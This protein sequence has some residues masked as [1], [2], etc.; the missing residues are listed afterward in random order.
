MVETILALLSQIFSFV[1]KVIPSDKLQQDR[2]E[3]NKPR[4]TSKEFTR[5]YDAEFRRLLHHT[6]I[7]IA[8]DV[9]FVNGS[10][11]AEDRIELIRLLTDRINAY[12][13]AHPIIFRKWIKL[14]KEKSLSK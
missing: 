6:E 5:L 4:L 8:T 10:L 7:D 1:A 2:F 11:A 14:Q 13:Y 9:N 12:R 3:L